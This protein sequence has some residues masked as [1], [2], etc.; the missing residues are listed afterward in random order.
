MR[1]WRFLIWTIT[2]LSLV[3]GPLYLLGQSCPDWSAKFDQITDPAVRQGLVQQRQAGWASAGN[4]QQVIA[5]LNDLRSQASAK[6]AADQTI[7]SQIGV[8]AQSQPS[9]ADC[10]GTSALSAAR[11][12]Y[13]QMSQAMLAADGSLEIYQCLAGRTGAISFSSAQT[14][15]VTQAQ[16]CRPEAEQRRDWENGVKECINIG[17][18]F[19]GDAAIQE[20]T[21]KCRASQFKPAPCQASTTGSS[22]TIRLTTLNSSL[23][24]MSQLISVLTSRVESNTPLP[25]QVQFEKFEQ[26]VASQ[27]VLGDKAQL[28]DS[29]VNNSVAELVA[30]KVTPDLD[31]E[32]KRGCEAQVADARASGIGL[33][34]QACIDKYSI[35]TVAENTK[36]SDKKADS[37]DCANVDLGTVTELQGRILKLRSAL[38]DANSSRSDVS[39]LAG[40]GDDAESA[41][42]MLGF[43]TATK[44][45]AN[46]TLAALSMGTG[47]GKLITDA[48]DYAGG[49]L[50]F[51]NGGSPSSR[52]AGGLT[53][54]DKVSNAGPKGSPL[55]IG[56]SVMTTY[57]R[58]QK[59]DAAGTV[60]H[61]AEVVSGL[62]KVTGVISEK[63]ADQY[64]GNLVKIS[65]SSKEFAEGVRVYGESA[66]EGDRLRNQ[67]VSVL[68]MIDQTRSTLSA[69][70][71][72]LEAELKKIGPCVGIPQ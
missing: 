26:S 10:A 44:G 17:S 37:P 41:G 19:P 54:A 64:V 9:Q 32:I 30:D 71:S 61:S 58:V 2:S 7:M 18:L 69:K 57:D 11:C 56:A 23:T 33:T 51:L 60:A 62:G 45:A 43:L 27:A 53:A 55:G 28:R 21:R 12:D 14:S 48:A 52:L 42:H 35:G 70:I 16:D 15:G 67:N 3:I 31:E 47:E 50:D 24:S 1:R 66:A 59:G 72:A 6:L 40:A 8:G 25:S 22:S 34:L 46:G 49:F 13:Y 63:V 65:D 20:N 29:T 36:S 38:Y 4:P 5:S 39:S 68:R